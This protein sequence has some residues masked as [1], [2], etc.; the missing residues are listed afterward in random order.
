MISRLPVLFATALATAT[1]TNHLPAQKLPLTDELTMQVFD[2]NP[3]ALPPQRVE[4]AHCD[5]LARF[6]RRFI[7]PPL[8]TGQD[9]ELLGTHHLVIAGTARQCA[10]VERFVKRCTNLRETQ[11]DIETALIELSASQFEAL[12][13]PVFAAQ[14]DAKS[15]GNDAEA[16]QRLAVLARPAVAKLMRQ[17][18]A[19]AVETLSSPRILVWHS[20]R[21]TMSVGENVP[22]VSDFEIVD[23]DGKERIVA[24][25][26]TLFDGI[27]VDLQAASLADGFISLDC[28][29]R[30]SRV[31]R[32]LPKAIVEIRK[33]VERIVHLPRTRQVE[34]TQQL[35]LPKDSGGVVAVRRNDGRW[36]ITIVTA[37]RFE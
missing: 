19:A 5:R 27:E 11:V 18:A 13:A 26:N 7:E 6:A 14:D 21:A 22:Y 30:H 23:E 29:M 20:Q 16:T 15:D 12:V 31:L 28:T 34:C 2:L 8:A 3:V 37:S 35:V 4:A 36:L 25:R 32:P 17:F 1:I 24:K 9:I 10:W 33:D